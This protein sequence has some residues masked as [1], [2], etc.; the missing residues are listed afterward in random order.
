MP[1]RIQPLTDLLLMSF[2]AGGGGLVAAQGGV[3]GVMD[4]AQLR[5]WCIVGSVMGAALSVIFTPPKTLRVGVFKW[6]GSLLTSFMFTPSVF[7]WLDVDRSIDAVL[8]I[9]GLSA[10]LAWYI[11]KA[12]QSVGGRFVK[13]LCEKIL[14]GVAD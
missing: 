2:V 3:P 9:A 13:R 7:L 5:A 11:L 1:H 10:F 14:G 8:P 12:L 4:D 6:L